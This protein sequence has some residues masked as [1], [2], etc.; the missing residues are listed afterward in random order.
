MQRRTPM[1]YNRSILA[2]LAAGAA[3]LSPAVAQEPAKVLGRIS[4][5]GEGRAA[6]VPDTAVFDASVVIAEIAQAALE[7][8]TKAITALLA[9]LKAAGIEGRDLATAGFAVQPRIVYPQ[10]EPGKQPEQPKLDGYEVRNSVKARVRDLSKLGT[11]LD[12]AVQHGAN[13]I[14]AIS[15]DI[16]NK[17]VLLDKARQDAINDAK[18]KAEK[19]APA[20]IK[21]GRVLSLSEIVQHT[22][23]PM[24]GDGMSLR[25]AG[26][27]VPVEPGEQSLGAH[28]EMTWGIAN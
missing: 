13:Q 3:L 26:A 21:L 16:Q 22:P 19:A 24:A 12:A 20:G 1:K 17:D 4:I 5:V 9:A 10:P 7:Q 27:P 11:M 2:I 25:G 15:F 28:V 18:R 6:A 23:H 14:G 8:N